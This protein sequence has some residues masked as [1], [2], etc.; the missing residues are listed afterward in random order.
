[1]ETREVRANR[2][3]RERS[4]R[5]EQARIKRQA[6]AHIQ[7]R[8]GQLRARRR[9]ALRFVAGKCREARHRARD[10]IKRRRVAARDA[11]RVE[12]RAIR[13]ECSNRCKL[14]K[15]RVRASYDGAIARER[16]AL[17]ERR[18]R[19]SLSRKLDTHRAKHAR[20]HRAAERRSES[21]DEVRANIPA[22]LVAIFDRVRSKVRGSPGLSRTEAFTHWIEEHPDE[23]WRIHEEQAAAELARLLREQKRQS[24]RPVSTRARRA[25]LEVAP[26]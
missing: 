6:L 8:I 21:D 9:Q 18:E 10:A 1:M 19:E 17:V 11:L 4:A 2:K 25:Q 12:L 20:K 5:I 7:A 23:V 14:R 22:E 15:H 3:H 26:F 24:P 16:A 13:S